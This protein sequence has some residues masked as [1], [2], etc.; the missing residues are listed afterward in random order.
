MENNTCS[1]CDNEARPGQ[2]YCNPCHAEF[3]RANRP[4]YSELSPE[5]KKKD[6]ARSYVGVYVRRGKITK[7]PCVKCGNE[8]SQAHHEDYN[9]PLDVIWLCRECHMELHNV[10]RGTINK[11]LQ[12]A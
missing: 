6:C 11:K 12:V 5:Q 9:K 10:A 8:D 4:T 7:E 3:M 1:K 2:R